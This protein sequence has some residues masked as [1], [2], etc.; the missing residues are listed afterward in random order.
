M[1][2]RYPLHWPVGY[3]RTKN[4]SSSRFKQTGENAQIHLRNEIH[5]LGANNLIV[6]TNCQIRNDGYVYSDMSMAKLPDPGVAIYFNYKGKDVSMC[7]DTYLTVCE[8][9]YALAKGIEAIRAIERYGI[10][11]FM[12]RAFTGFKELP[13]SSQVELPNWWD[14]LEVKPTATLDDV[15]EAYRRLAIRYHPDKPGTGNAEKFI[16]VQKAY[17]HAVKSVK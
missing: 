1:H 16:Q 6:S 10:S 14:I 13:A 7:C 15:K 4:R 12:E 11:E 5:R 17:E 2:Q 8:N 9:I 3:K